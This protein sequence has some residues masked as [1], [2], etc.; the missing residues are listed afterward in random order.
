MDDLLY[1]TSQEDGNYSHAVDPSDRTV[2]ICGRIQNPTV[3]GESWADAPA[4]RCQE[5]TAQAR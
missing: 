4:P 1:G 3:N 2:S 5:C